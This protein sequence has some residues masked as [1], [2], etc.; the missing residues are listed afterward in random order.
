MKFD[1]RDKELMK[2]LVDRIHYRDW[3][4]NTDEIRTE[5]KLTLINDFEIIGVSV[6][7]D[8]ADFDNELGKF[9]SMEDAMRQLRLI[10]DFMTHAQ[11]QYEQF[12]Q[13]NKEHESGEEKVK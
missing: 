1:K 6:C 2:T 4:E 5:C 12:K 7:F 10:D 3:Q 13:W 9:Y 11:K 8:P